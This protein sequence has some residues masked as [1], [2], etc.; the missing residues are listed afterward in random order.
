MSKTTSLRLFDGK[1]ANY[2]AWKTAARKFALSIKAD[3]QWQGKGRP[4]DLPTSAGV[5]QKL[6][7]EHAQQQWDEKMQELVG[8]L[9]NAHEEDSAGDI[10]ATEYL[11]LV[12]ADDTKEWNCK[13]FIEHMDERFDNTT[14]MATKFHALQAWMK[15]KYTGNL[16]SYVVKFKKAVRD[17]ARLDPP[18]EFSV[19]AFEERFSSAKLASKNVAESRI[20]IALIIL[21]LF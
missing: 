12:E 3:G 11:E 17:L 18:E 21:I 5:A 15:I 9:L 16:S 2:P 10:A 14:S 4:E 6:A 20:A 8:T 19:S 1:A 13:E 7:R